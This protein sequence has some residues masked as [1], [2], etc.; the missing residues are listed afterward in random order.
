MRRAAPGRFGTIVAVIAAAIVG[1]AALAQTP[2][3]PPPELAAVR[4]QAMAALQAGKLDEAVTLWSKAVELRPDEPT[5]RY[6]LACALARSGDAAASIASLTAAAERGFSNSLLLESDADLESV[7]TD[8]AF[9]ALVARVKAADP[10]RQL[11]FWIGTW[12][13]YTTADVKV[14]QNIIEPRNKGRMLFEQW[15]DGRGWVGCSQNFYDHGKKQ[16]RQVWTDEAGAVIDY[17]GTWSDG[18]MRL[19]GTLTASHGATSK[20][21]MTL[22]PSADGSVR[23]VIDRQAADGTWTNAVDFR[24]VRRAS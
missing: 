1:V 17:A 21:R 24:Y 3:S 23:Q 14:G 19:E 2:A 20:S 10:V 12:D 4:Q 9:A 16:W 18:A 15:T 8:P 6:N 11:D 7:R 5:D 22:T 13:V